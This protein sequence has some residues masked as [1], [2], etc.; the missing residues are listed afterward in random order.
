MMSNRNRVDVAELKRLASG[1]MMEILAAAGVPA[2]VLANPAREHP[3]P[4]CGG[5]TRFRL[6]DPDAGAVR[7]SHCHA[8]K[9]GDVIASVQF[10]KQTDFRGAMI[11]LTEYLGLSAPA[12]SNDHKS[13]GA[14]PA[15]KFSSDPIGEL[16][17]AKNCPRE[18]LVAFG[19]TSLKTD[20]GKDV[21]VFPVFDAEGKHSSQFLFYSPS[22]KGLC[23]KGGTH[24]LFC[25]FRNDPDGCIAA[26]FPAAGESVC[27]V[28]GV[29]DAAAIEGLGYRAIGLPMHT[30][31]K[32]FAPA[33]RDLDTIIIPDRDQVGVGGAQKTAQRLQGVAAAVRIAEL[34]CPLVES[35]GAD[36]RD[37]LKLEGGE[38]LVRQAIEQ[39]RDAS[40][41][42]PKDA[43]LNE[44][45]D[46]PPA[47]VPFPVGLLPSPVGDYV[48]EAAAA[49]GC[50]PAYVALPMLA[51]VAGAVGNSCRVALKESWEEPAVVWAAIIGPSGTMKSPAFEKATQTLQRIQTKAFRDFKEKEKSYKALKTAYDADLAAWKRA[52]RDQRGELP[53]EPAEPTAARFVVSDA[54]IEAVCS[55][56][57]ENPRGVLLA[58]DEL[59]G[60][61]SSFDAYKQQRGG[62][63]AHWL[64]AHRAGPITV[65]RKTGRRIVHVPRGAISITGSIQPE[66]LARA[67]GGRYAGEEGSGEHFENGLAARLLFA[68]PPVR[69]KRWT[70]AVIPDAT[71]TATDAIIGRLL[72]LPLETDCDGGVRPEI[73][74]LSPAARGRFIDFYNAHAKETAAL[75]GPLASAWAKL[76]GGAARFALLVELIQNAAAGYTVAPDT[77]SVE[78]MNAGIELSN[79]FAEEAARVYGIIGA[80]GDTNRK[81][82][83]Q[84]RLIA[85]IGD[86]G[87][88]ATARDLSRGPRQFRG[89]AEAAETA[90]V[91]LAESGHGDWVISHAT[92][93][94]GRPTRVFRLTGGDETPEN[95]GVQEVSSPVASSEYLKMPPAEDR[96]EAEVAGVLDAVPAG[97]GW[98]EV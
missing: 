87:G 16:A 44:P 70:D 97:G 17:A 5:E 56:L 83:E 90:L 20:Q 49:L 46:E 52:K 11:W 82:R 37:V 63:V 89:D 7:C 27:V 51:A 76:E 36:V 24:G 34:P 66:T 25:R 78:S 50:D 19:A 42:A 81:A 85:W 26:D 88:E 41:T 4:H 33:F 15:A 40:S 95:V 18:H 47:Y 58:R 91:D 6:I 69:P 39:A 93:S 10:A 22:H 55:V 61:L 71:A 77:I 3:C 67:L 12:A 59:S 54:T 28:E 1:R 32:R 94:G 30:M 73:I 21:V 43:G 35:H 65:D 2:E 57:E 23:K 68:F 72:A 96:N 31:A 62:D 14:A 64:S 45:T 79:W 13:N 48:A 92:D 98:G 86:Q 74:P 84:S 53:E 38:R 75:A 80:A 9:C 60:W 8:D 29:K